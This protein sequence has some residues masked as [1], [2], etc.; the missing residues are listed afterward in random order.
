[1]A[2]RPSSILPDGRVVCPCGCNTIVSDEVAHFVHT[3]GEYVTLSIPSVGR[4]RVPRA[5]IAVHGIRADQA[6]ALAQAYGWLIV[7]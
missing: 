6:Q 7:P 1:M 4:W 3:E 2:V 5:F